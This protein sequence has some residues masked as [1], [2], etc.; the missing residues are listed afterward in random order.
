MVQCWFR[1]QLDDDDVV[2]VVVGDI[3]WNE[4]YFVQCDFNVV[5]FGIGFGVFVGIGVQ[6]F[7][8]DVDVVQCGG[9][10][11]CVVDD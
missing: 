10:L 1:L 7:D 9:I 4:C 11:Y 8:V 2:V 6:C 5:F 3:V